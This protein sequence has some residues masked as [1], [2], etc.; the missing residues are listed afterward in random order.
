MTNFTTFE[1]V[2]SLVHSKKEHYDFADVVDLSNALNRHL[3]IGDIT[4]DV[5]DAI[6]SYIRFFNRLDE[7]EQ[8]PIEERQPIKILVNSPGGEVMAT[9]TIIDSIKNSKTPI[10]TVNTGT[11]YSGGFFIF[12]CG[13]KRFAYPHSSFLFHE[14]ST[15]TVGDAHKFNNW[16]DF[17]KKVL[18]K[19]RNI[20]LINTDISEELYDDHSKDDWWLFADEAIEL[21][22]CDE[23]IYSIM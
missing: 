17:Y 18:A 5:A 9:M 21:G 12:I 1:L 19:L 22:I 8:I 7:E 3:Y 6:D 11:A 23:I 16:A 15:G 4:S 2:D 10:W 20:T 13:H 14:G